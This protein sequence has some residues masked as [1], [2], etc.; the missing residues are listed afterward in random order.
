MTMSQILDH[1]E[2]DQDSTTSKS[3]GQLSV[4]SFASDFTDCT[5]LSFG[6]LMMNF[7]A[8]SAHEK[9]MVAVLAAVTEIIRSEGGQES[10]TE[11]FAALMTSLEGLETEDENVSAQQAAILS[12][13]VMSLKGVPKV[14][15][16]SRFDQSTTLLRKILLHESKGY[17]YFQR[18]TGIGFP[19][20][21][22]SSE[23]S[24][25]RGNKFDSTD[26]GFLN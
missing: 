18:Y 9:Q 5:N 21:T 7:R 15:L 12:L 26:S 6:K 16:S 11:Y 4:K 10:E 24:A 3:L 1:E 8:D 22:Q 20:K 17:G 2:M 13:I 23:G 25:T 14:V 19:H